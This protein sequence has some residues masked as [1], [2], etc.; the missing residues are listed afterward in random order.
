MAVGSDHTPFTIDSGRVEGLY[1]QLDMTGVELAHRVGRDGGIAA[2]VAMT[3]DA[4]AVHESAA[5]ATLFKEQLYDVL[6]GGSPLLVAILRLDACGAA[7]GVFAS[8]CDCIRQVALE[9][10][11]SPTAIGIGIAVSAL[12]PQAAWLLRCEHLGE[13]PLFLL[14]GRDLMSPDTTASERARHERF[15]SQMWHLRCTPMLQPAYAQAVSSQC[16]LLSD[17]VALSVL[18]TTAIQA[19]AGSAWLSLHL[20]V[21]RFAAPNGLTHDGALEQALCRAIEIGEELH[22]LMVWPN[23]RMR[24][25]A[26]LNRRLAIIVSGFGDLIK[27]RSLDPCDFAALQDLSA[28][29]SS[30]QAILLR[31][32]R[33]LAAKI[34]IL[35]ALRQADPS[36]ALPGGQVRNSWRKRWQ[37]AMRQAAIR[38]RNLLVLSPWCV[39]P[40]SDRA[41]IRYANLL[42]LLRFAD[43]CSFSGAPDLKHWSAGQF[44]NFH[45]RAWAVLQQREVANQIAERI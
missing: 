44:K 24:H 1:R 36:H 40:A 13:G 8:V 6:Q 28:T 25:D 35:P 39:F 29:A 5:A 20:D 16:P 30:I 45:Q 26:W 17:E 32:S 41:D 18:P 22:D 3:V 31:Q 27:M 2:D 10:G 4:I 43:A 19:P 11:V 21:T 14:P 12:S 23:A 42:P 33:R 34:D 9:V 38:H 37:L 7:R 15:W